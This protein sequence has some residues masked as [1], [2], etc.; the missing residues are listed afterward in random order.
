MVQTNEKEV[1][2]GFG[3]TSIRLR[4]GGEF[5]NRSGTKRSKAK[6]YEKIFDTQKDI[7]SGYLA[8]RHSFSTIKMIIL[9][10]WIDPTN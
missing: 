9:V 3:L 1:A 2:F 4:K 8:L 5:F 7:M 10:I 6:L